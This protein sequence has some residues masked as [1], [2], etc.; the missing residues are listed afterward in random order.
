MDETQEHHPEQG[1][2]DSEDQKLYVFSHIWTLDLG[3][4]Q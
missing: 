2:P 3:Q 4:K 1:L